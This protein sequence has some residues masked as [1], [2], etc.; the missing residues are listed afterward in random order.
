MPSE[1]G[2]SMLEVIRMFEP[3]KRAAGIKIKADS[4]QEAVAQAMSVMQR[5]GF[6]R[7]RKK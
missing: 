3:A 5:P 6:F 2:E 7:R 1:E 4:P